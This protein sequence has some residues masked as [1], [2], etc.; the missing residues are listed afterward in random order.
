MQATAKSFLPSAL[1]MAGTIYSFTQ[2]R[3]NKPDESIFPAIGRAAGY[4][5]VPTVMWASMFGSLAVALGEAGHA[6]W[7]GLGG[8]VRQ[9]ES[10][11][12]GGSFWDSEQAQAFRQQSVQQGL[13]S[14]QLLASQMGTEARRMHRRLYA[15]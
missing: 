13:T 12:L 2:D 7:R 15:G 6:R 5:F 4:F 3:R 8:E 11:G 10:P 14:R 9:A 1:N